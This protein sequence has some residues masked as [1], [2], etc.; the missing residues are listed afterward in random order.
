MIVRL[1]GWDQEY[2]A[3]AVALDLPPL[4]TELN[5]GRRRS[6]GWE[7]LDRTTD[8]DEIDW[9]VDVIVGTFD[10][11][12]APGVDLTPQWPQIRS[13]LRADSRVLEAAAENLR[14]P[15]SQSNGAWTADAHTHVATVRVRGRTV[16]DAEAAACTVLDDV[17]E[18]VGWTGRAGGAPAFTPAGAYPTGSRAAER[19]A[20]FRN[21]RA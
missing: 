3:G 21:G 7:F 15:V 12:A 1:S 4:P 19:N 20:G 2:S 10:L 6:A 8:D 13:A 18:A 11:A 14:L 9:V 5:L 16:A 17:A